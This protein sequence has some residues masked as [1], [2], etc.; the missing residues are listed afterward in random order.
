M[1]ASVRKTGMHPFHSKW[2]NMMYPRLLLAR[3]LLTDDGVLFAS[4]D[5]RELSCLRAVLIDV[6]GEECFVALITV[7]CNPK[8]RSQ[9]KY[10]ATNHEYVIAFSKTPL[11][12]GAFA[13]E[14]DEDQIAQEYAEEDESGKY[15]LLE[16]R[17][18]HREFGKHN[19]KNLFY[20]FFVDEDGNVFLDQ[21]N[22]LT[23]VLPR[24][25]DGYEGCWTWDKKKASRDIDFL[26][27][28]MVKGRWK[29]FRKS[30]ASGAERMLKTIFF[31]KDFYT[32]R[33]K[34]YLT[35][36]LPQRANCFSRRSHLSSS[37]S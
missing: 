12:K 35:N 37:R 28:Q 17:N 6:F 27:A 33:G 14:K 36:C 5:E 10:S 22:G 11:P 21:S 2:L 20:P 3:N 1:L 32:E 13:I 19:R 16:L 4:I 24:W 15:R 26:T 30:Y 9:D 31:D 29:I 18:T 7:L 8:G 34:R 25:N 23:E